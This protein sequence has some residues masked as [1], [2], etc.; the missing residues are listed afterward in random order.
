MEVP[1]STAHELGAKHTYMLALGQSRPEKQN[2]ITS[3][4][5]HLL[6]EFTRAC[7]GAPCRGC[8]L[9]RQRTEIRRGPSIHHRVSADE[10]EL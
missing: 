10:D 2:T 9:I 5:Q 7:A 8:A 3:Y 6:S 4:V 1:K